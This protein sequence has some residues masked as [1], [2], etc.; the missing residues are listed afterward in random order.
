LK[1]FVVAVEKVIR[2]RSPCGER[3]LKFSDTYATAQS[4][5]SLPLRGA[6]VEMIAPALIKTHV[7]VAPLAGSVG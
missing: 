6:W 1:L 2:R 4:E 7:Y 3:G 5:L